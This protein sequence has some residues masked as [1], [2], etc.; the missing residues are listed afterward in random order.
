[1]D[2]ALAPWIWGAAAALCGLT[3]WLVNPVRGV[4]RSGGNAMRGHPSPWLV[5]GLLLAADDALLRAAPA[6]AAGV[7]PWWDQAL[8][9]T[10]DSLAGIW[11]GPFLS[12]TAALVGGVAWLFNAGGIRRGVTSGLE[13]VFGAGSARWAG[14]LA[15]GIPALAAEIALRNYELPAGWRI[16]VILLTAPLH[17]WAAVLFAGGIWLFAETQFRAPSKTAKIR[18]PETAAAHSI[19]LWP[20]V[21]AG[22][23]AWVA[24]RLLPPVAHPVLRSGWWGLAVLS[25]A[26]PLVF[27]HVPRAG[28]FSAGI[29]ESAKRLRTLLPAWAGFTAA[30]GMVLLAWHAAEV[31]LRQRGPDPASPAGLALACLLRLI[32]TWLLVRAMCGWVAA[33]SGKHRPARP[34][35]RR[36]PP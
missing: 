30:A 33:G 36:S 16:A 22:A 7:Q 15:A 11:S 8:R 4:I 13:S 18:W 20:W 10:A 6:H 5:P 29:R 19:R 9:S 24:W 14:W 27:L 17:G 21:V 28:D 25:C 35:G 32:H 23:V 31:A 34:A 3:F 12:Q 1:M 26:A 2:P